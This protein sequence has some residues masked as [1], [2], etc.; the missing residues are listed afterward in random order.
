MIRFLAFTALVLSMGAVTCGELL[1]LN[2]SAKSSNSP[3][4]TTSTRICDLLSIDL[5]GGADDSRPRAA[6]DREV[7]QCPGCDSDKQA[8]RRRSGDQY[9][10][11]SCYDHHGHRPKEHRYERRNCRY[12]RH[13]DPAQGY[14]KRDRSFEQ[15]RD[16]V[17]CG[18]SHHEDPK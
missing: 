13:F 14:D 4:G 17:R 11:S 10:Y 18:N 8:N 6:Q 7:R 1:R 16:E 3:T 12:D 5:G 15:A 9:H 2:V